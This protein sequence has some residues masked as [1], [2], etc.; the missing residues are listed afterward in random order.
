MYLYSLQGLRCTYRYYSEERIHPET[1][2]RLSETIPCESITYL[3]TFNQAEH[4]LN[5]DKHTCDGQLMN[6]IWLLGNTIGLRKGWD[7]HKRNGDSFAPEVAWG[8]Q[9]YYYIQPIMSLVVP[10]QS[11]RYSPPR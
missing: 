8:L 1:E 6:Q 4:S 3:R 5:P 7:L 10:P 2:A 11:L 9:Y